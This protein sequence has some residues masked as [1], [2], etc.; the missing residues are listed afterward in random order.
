MTFKI[1]SAKLTLETMKKQTLLSLVLLGIAGLISAQPFYYSGANS[2]VFRPG[3]AHKQLVEAG[4]TSENWQRKDLKKGE[5][6]KHQ[7][8]QYSE[9]G[10]LVS[11][12]SYRKKGTKVRS[13]RYYAYQ[14]DQLAAYLTLNKDGDSISWGTYTY[15]NGKQVG[16]KHYTKKHSINPHYSNEVQLDE[17]GRIKET[18]Y[19]VKGKQVSR[20]VNAYTEDGKRVESRYYDRKNKL[21]SIT[22]YACDAKGETVKSEVKLRNYCTRKEALPNGNYLEISEYTNHKGKVF[23]TVSTFNKDSM[24]VEQINFTPEGKESYKQVNA[25]V[26]TKLLSRSESFRK[27]KAIWAYEMDYSTNG[28]ATSSRTFNSKGKLVDEFK[29]NWSKAQ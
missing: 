28:F 19:K 6:Y 1:V 16:Y 9:D 14:N 5:F 17:N 4:Y 2:F 29:I 7:E 12:I 20:Y 18:I 10:Y 11:E 8:K 26:Q 21:V 23:R 25:Y 27:G 15:L 3:K 13:A 22:S 24:L